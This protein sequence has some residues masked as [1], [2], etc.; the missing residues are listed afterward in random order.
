MW[1]ETESDSKNEANNARGYFH[2]PIGL[3]SKNYFRLEIPLM[4][5]RRWH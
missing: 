3:F 5:Y 2:R 4:L 1:F